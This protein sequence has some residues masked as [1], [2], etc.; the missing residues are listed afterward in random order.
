MS[1][2]SLAINRIK[3]PNYKKEGVENSTFSFLFRQSNPVYF[4]KRKKRK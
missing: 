2:K 3:K 4:P 1:K